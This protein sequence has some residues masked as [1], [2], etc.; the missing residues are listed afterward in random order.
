MEALSDY[1]SQ[2][3]AVWERFCA[4][5]PRVREPG[6]IEGAREV[7]REAMK[8]VRRN[9]EILIDRWNQHGYRFGY[10][11]TEPAE[12][13][14]QLIADAPPI[15]AIPTEDDIRAIDKFEVMRGPLPVALKALYEVVGATNLVGTPP[16]GWPDVEVLDPLQIYSLPPQLPKLRADA[17]SK[18]NLCDDCLGKYLFSNVGPLE[19]RVTNHCFD[20][21]ILFE[22][23]DVQW[24]GKPLTLG[25]YLREVI[26]RRGGIG[27]DFGSNDD[28]AD[29]DL[30][31][32]LTEGL[33][34]F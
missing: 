1:L 17:E 16:D 25:R 32:S 23:G 34:F 31:A 28:G 20:P 13:N 14:Q 19:I 22:D 26:L 3:Q 30:I 4:L 27:H 2:P 15:L 21:K 5:G 11:W 33:L 9:I 18:I 6:W 8:R 29:P 7:A 10:D 24:Q 12:W